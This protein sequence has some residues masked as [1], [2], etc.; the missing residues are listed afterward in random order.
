MIHRRSFVALIAASSL[1]LG[2]TNAALAQTAYPSKTVTEVVTF[3][4]GG[5]GDVYGRAIAE[6]LSAKLGQSV[7]VDNRVGGGGLIGASSVARAAPDGH[8][9]MLMTG[10]HIGAALLQPNPSVD[11][12]EDLTPVVGVGGFP[13]I[14]VAPISSEIKSFADIKTHA[15][16]VDA[17][18]YASGGIGSY[19]HMGAAYLMSALGVQSVHLPFAGNS[20]A[21]Q[22]LM[23]GE[24]DLIFPAS[25]DVLELVRAGKLRALA[26]SSKERIAAL[27]DVPTMAELGYP[28]IDPSVWYGFLV[29]K[30]TPKEIVDTLAT[31]ISEAAMS[32]TV[33]SL[34]EK[35]NYLPEIIDGA[36]LREKGLAE[37]ARWGKV[38]ADNKIT[39]TN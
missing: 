16:K 17:L 36:A 29:P 10:A 39:L 1:A 7:V 14:L 4:A 38:I 6:Q 21:I 12:L 34:F 35:Y 9:F 11:I 15:E 13:G 25:T 5:I 8:T 22:S 3:S 28:D 19:G 32:D 31:A 33:K 18:N 2:A 27:P 24:I 30:D 23:G 26:V 20:T 37:K